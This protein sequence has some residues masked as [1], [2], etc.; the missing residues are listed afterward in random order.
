M[1]SFGYAETR[2][3]SDERPSQSWDQRRTYEQ[4][5]KVKLA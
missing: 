1:K 2:R 3:K 5:F 4:I